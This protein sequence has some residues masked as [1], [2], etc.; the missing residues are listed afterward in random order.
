[1]ANFSVTEIIVLARDKSD[2]V[3]QAAD[4]YGATET[5]TLSGTSQNTF[6]TSGVGNNTTFVRIAATTDAHIDIGSSPTADTNSPILP[7][8]SVEYVGIKQ[9]EKVAART[10]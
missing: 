10:T 1:M 7:A 3:I 2:Q 9:G 8:G 5:L 6:D 4:R